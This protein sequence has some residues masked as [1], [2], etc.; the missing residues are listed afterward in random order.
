MNER[1]I[2]LRPAYAEAARIERRSWSRALAAS[3]LSSPQRGS[4]EKIL[5]R[6]WPHDGRAT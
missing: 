6:N 2:P 1:P 3:A 4:A 5:A